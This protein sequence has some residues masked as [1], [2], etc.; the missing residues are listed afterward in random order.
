MNVH[1]QDICV[2]YPPITGPIPYPTPPMRVNRVLLFA[3]SSKETLSA[4]ITFVKISMPEQPIPCSALPTRSIGKAETGAAEHSALPM[5]M[6]HTDAC[7]VSYRPNT[8][9]HWPQAGMKVA[10]QR[11]NAD[12]IQLSCESLSVSIRRQ[13]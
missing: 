5:S 12:T 13:W 7:S 2:K 3:F 1:L 4:R 11:L 8:S 6:I 10:E 9:E